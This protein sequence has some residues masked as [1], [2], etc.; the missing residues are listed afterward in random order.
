MNPLIHDRLA[1]QTLLQA[2]ADKTE[3]FFAG[4]K[5]ITGDPYQVKIRSFGTTRTCMARGHDWLNRATLTGDES[6]ELIDEIIA[7]YA[8]HQ[9]RCHIEWN[10]GNCHRPGTWNAELGM[11]LLARGFQPGSFR[12]VWH[13][14][15][16]E[17]MADQARGV[18]VRCF[19][20]GDREEFLAELF[21]MEEKTH[22]QKK[23]MKEKILHG[24]NSPQ[25]HHYIAYSEDTPCATATLFENGR[26]AYLDWAFTLESARKRGCQG[27]LIRQRL[28]D[29]RRLGCSQAA[30]VTDIGSDSARNL[31]HLGF[32]LAYNYVMLIRE[33]DSA[34]K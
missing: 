27:A 22:E 9:Q 21:T 23:E 19:G 32:Q 31:Q 24:Q 30:S 15:V 12:C 18:R 2:Y 14:N 26:I 10:P 11:R 1:V 20:P 13:T 25:W 8:E 34:K 17:P 5:K 6:F 16:S 7:F 29:A 3:S 33:P 4:L 28:R